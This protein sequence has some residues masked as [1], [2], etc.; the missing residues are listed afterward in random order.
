MWQSLHSKISIKYQTHTHCGIMTFKG[1]GLE[2]LETKWPTSIEWARLYTKMWDFE[3]NQLLATR[4]I[5]RISKLDQKE[6]RV[7]ETMSNSIPNQ[8]KT[9]IQQCNCQTFI[10]I[11]VGCFDTNEQEVHPTLIFQSNIFFRPM[12]DECHGPLVLP[13]PYVF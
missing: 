10:G 11:W 8:W 9:S 13:N 7:H 5:L 1:W 3:N 2:S 12:L 4:E 6:F